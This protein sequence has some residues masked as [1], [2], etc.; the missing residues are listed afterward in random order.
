MAYYVYDADG[1]RYSAASVGTTTNYVV[2]TS[3][4]YAS[5][6]EEYSNGTLA[7]RYDYGDDLV[8]M[9]RGSGVYY[10]IYDGLGSTRQLISTAG[11]VTDSWGYSAFGELASH[12]GSTTNLFLFNA[13]QIDA[14]SGDY[15]LRARYYD[16]SSGRLLAQDP[17]EGNAHDP[18][19]LHRYLYAGDDS[20]NFADPTGK[21][22]EET[23]ATTATESILSATILPVIEVAGT[24]A[25]ESVFGAVAD[26]ALNAVATEAESAISGI[27][28]DASEDLIS[29]AQSEIERLNEEAVGQDTAYFRSWARRSAFGRNA[30]NFA[31]KVL[32]TVGNFRKT[33][34]GP[35]FVGKIGS[36][37]LQLEAKSNLP[38]A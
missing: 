6:V 10:Y 38:S 17:F 31:Q 25:A 11:A 29:Q 30:E 20:V 2:D 7:A 32:N 24:E 27:A 36:K 37:L 22:I 35:D 5:V 3:L 26:E 14:G 13:Q 33:A 8:R 9:D 18:I 15:Y 28:D 12:T 34:Q 16:P 4:P 1:N 23:L 21:E 19:T